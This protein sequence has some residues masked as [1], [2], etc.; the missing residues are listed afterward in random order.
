MNIFPKMEGL[1]WHGQAPL[2]DKP[3]YLIQ[4]FLPM[5]GVGLLVGEPKV[6]KTFLTISMAVSIAS[7]SIFLGNNLA[8]STNRTWRPR[9]IESGSTLILAGEGL[10][11]YPA[12]IQAAFQGLQGEYLDRLEELELGNERPVAHMYAQGLRE[13]KLYEQCLQ[14]ICE[15]S[16]HLDS[17]TS[18][19]LR[20]IVV[21][22]LAA[23]FGFK[24]E[25]SA[26]EAQG[27]MNK[28]V[29]LSRETGAFVLATGHPSK[30]SRKDMV[31]GSS[32][33][34][35]A[36]DVI[37]TAHR[38]GKDRI[39][40]LTVTKARGKPEDATNHVFQLAPIKLANDETCA[41][42]T[43]YAAI[44]VQ[45]HIPKAR[46]P[47]TKDAR[48]VLCAIKSLLNQKP[49][50]WELEN[51]SAFDAVYGKDIRRELAKVKLLES[52]IPKQ[53][54]DALRKS[55][56]R[57]IERLLAEEVISYD[58]DE[59]VDDMLY[60]IVYDPTPNAD[61]TIQND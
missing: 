3:N 32:A 22:T 24:D 55:F 31:R 5:T 6:G 53:R 34:E 35:A 50:L 18:F 47:L 2:P 43:T 59:E 51:G 12:R 25:N 26:A 58:T 29:R 38:R 57:G 54:A 44:P 19:G 41:Y 11:T 60:W 61:D 42:V 48:D 52:E 1:V 40:A 20:L 39:R 30:H 21:D 23:V 45:G 8:A 14:Q 10:S 13:D 28:L 7:G 15:L 37:I 33:F 49:V 9:L 36:A 56:Q 16:E 4:G 27:A 17:F 46:D